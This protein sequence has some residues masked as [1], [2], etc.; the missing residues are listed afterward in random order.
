MRQQV[1]SSFDLQMAAEREQGA[2]DAILRHI[3][4]SGPRNVTTAARFICFEKVLV[5]VSRVLRLTMLASV[6]FI[7]GWLLI[8]GDWWPSALQN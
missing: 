6:F 3:C 5:E 4:L 7:L 8:L 2:R 1:G